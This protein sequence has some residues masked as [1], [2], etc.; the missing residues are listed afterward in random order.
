MSETHKVVAA[1]LWKLVA[2]L[3][4]RTGAVLARYET[5]SWNNAVVVSG[6]LCCSVG[7]DWNMAFYQLDGAQL[8][9]CSAQTGVADAGGDSVLCVSL[10]PCRAQ[11]RVLGPLSA[12]RVAQQLLLRAEPFAC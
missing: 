9:V 11:T 1:S 8:R 2:L 6:S 5:V 3:D 10:A 12:V 7:D 4:S